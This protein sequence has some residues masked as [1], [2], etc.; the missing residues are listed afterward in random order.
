MVWNIGLRN[1]KKKNWGY[2]IENISEWIEKLILE[3]INNL[4]KK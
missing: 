2:E 3:E 4:G 1:S